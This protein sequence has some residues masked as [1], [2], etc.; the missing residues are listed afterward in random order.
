[1]LAQAFWVCAPSCACEVNESLTPYTVQR[2]KISS[3]IFLLRIGGARVSRRAQRG[4]W[5]CGRLLVASSTD[6]GS[7]KRRNVRK[8]WRS[9]PSTI[10]KS[11]T[12]PSPSRRRHRYRWQSLSLS[13]DIR[14]RMQWTW[15]LFRRRALKHSLN[16]L[17]INFHLCLGKR[18]G[19]R[20]S[21]HQRSWWRRKQACCP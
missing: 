12:A 5:R 8:N 1:M 15:D 10:P 21:A 6:E 11:R 14:R 19:N 17:S 18:D 3:A 2:S 20:Q 7:G 16:L 13:L 4:V 9:T